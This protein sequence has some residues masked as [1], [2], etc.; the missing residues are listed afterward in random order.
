[1]PLSRVRVCQFESEW[2]E[3]FQN[4]YKDLLDEIREKKQISTELEG[5]LKTICKEFSDQFE[6]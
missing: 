4:N 3:Y 6:V 2:I 5:K 1:M